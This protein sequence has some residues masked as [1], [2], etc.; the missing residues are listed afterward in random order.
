MTDREIFFDHVRREPFGGRLSAAQVAGTEALLDW[1]DANKPGGDVRQLAYVL[2]TAFHETGARMVPVREGFAADDAQARERVASL[3]R[4]RGADSAVARYARPDPETGEVYYG[5]GHVQLTWAENYRQMGALLGLPLYE[6]PDLALDPAVSARILFEGMFRGAS[7]RG[8]FT[9]KSLEDYF[10]P[11]GS[12][13]VAARAIVNGSDKAHLIAG[14]HAAFLEALL[15]AHGRPPDRDVTEPPVETPAPVY[16]EPP[17]PLRRS[18]TMRA[19]TIAGAA[20]TMS[21]VGQAA[22]AVDPKGDVAQAI[23]GNAWLPA[24]LVAIAVLGIGYM[25]YCRWDDHRKA[26]R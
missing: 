17:K 1:W 20:G 12:D 18:R 13:P 19:G 3:A 6:D 24:A 9:G 26:R 23:L 25:L 2:A 21:A 8:D 10:T 7:G 14:Y 15:A 16:P 22:R 11:Y 5:R 4:R